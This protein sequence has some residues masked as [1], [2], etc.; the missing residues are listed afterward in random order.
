MGFLRERSHKQTGVL[1]RSGFT[2]QPGKQGGSASLR[3]DSLHRDISGEGKHPGVVNTLLQG[4]G[5]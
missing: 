2:W 4:E 3:G 1:C 5:L